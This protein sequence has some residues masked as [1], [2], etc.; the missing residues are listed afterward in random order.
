MEDAT[1]FKVCSIVTNSATCK[2]STALAVEDA[3]TYIC[4]VL[5]DRAAGKAD[6]PLVIV[7]AAAF[8]ESFISNNAAVG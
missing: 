6:S 2:A 7:N 4:R 3:C 1:T 8:D 5:A